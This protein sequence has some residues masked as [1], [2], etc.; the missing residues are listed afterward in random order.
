MNTERFPTAATAGAGTEGLR[1]VLIVSGS[2]RYADPWHPFA[3]TSALLAELLASA[4]FTVTVDDDLDSA[5]T[6]LD[7][8]SLLVVNAGDPWRDAP[9]EP[10]PAESIA[11]FR[12]AVQDGVAILALHTAPATMRGY[13]DWAPAIGAVWLPGISGH[14][15]IGSVD[16]SIHD[17]RF[18]GTDSFRVID[19]RY[20]HLQPIGRSAVVATHQIDG[21]THPT[22]WIRTV[23]SL[24]VAVDLLGH[25]DHSYASEGHRAL[26]VA[27]AR[28]AT[29]VDSHD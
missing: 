21:A 10:A 9:P 27:L 12:Q 24:R 16:I 7:G 28:W 20:C 2:G 26:I 3:A 22:A 15:P 5:M 14:P 13:P 29:G 18:G 17:R 6:R 11:G 23:G 25:N 1:Q 19:E 8:V 4:G